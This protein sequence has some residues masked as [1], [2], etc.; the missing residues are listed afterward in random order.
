MDCLLWNN[1]HLY[2]LIWSKHLFPDKMTYSTVSTYILLID[3]F[4]CFISF[5]MVCPN[6]KYQSHYQ[7]YQLCLSLCQN[8]KHG[9]HTY[10]LMIELYWF[11]TNDYFISL[12]WLRYPI[13]IIFPPHIFWQIIARKLTKALHSWKGCVAC[14]FVHKTGK[15]LLSEYWIDI[16]YRFMQKSR[17]KK[18]DFQKMGKYRSETREEKLTIILLR[19]T[20]SNLQSFLAIC[21]HLWKRPQKMT[22][23]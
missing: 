18:F 20:C 19:K 22:I 1:I 4:V 7:C 9:K 17:Y 21:K 23:V 12:A 16:L 5:G 8:I 6:T 2:F 3:L 11:F 14:L 10:M 13:I 15:L